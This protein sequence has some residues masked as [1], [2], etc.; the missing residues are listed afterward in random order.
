MLRLTVGNC[1]AARN[2]WLSTLRRHPV[3]SVAANEAACPPRLPLSC[4][5]DGPAVI[6]RHSWRRCCQLLAHVAPFHGRPF[7]LCRAPAL[8]PTRFAVLPTISCR[9]F[10][11]TPSCT[12]GI[13]PTEYAVPVRAAPVLPSYA[14]LRPAA[15]VP[16][17]HR[18]LI[19]SSDGSRARGV[20][21][22]P[23]LPSTCGCSAQPA[24]RIG[25][26]AHH[27]LWVGAAAKPHSVWK[28]CITRRAGPP[29][30]H[31][32]TILPSRTIP[33]PRPI[34]RRGPSRAL[35]LNWG[36]APAG[37]CSQDPN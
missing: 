9:G 7:R 11:A 29:S 34:R 10:A 22:R 4:T 13:T 37:G 21:R 2:R 6:P 31:E 16:S 27:G 15:S 20:S 33:R 25:T 36:R 8:P 35:S 3:G 26:V 1:S 18:P 19:T 14:T 32:R 30:I 23:P 12:V 5:G 24:I 28:D 17:G